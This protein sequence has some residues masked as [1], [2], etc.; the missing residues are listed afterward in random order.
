MLY[1]VV[2]QVIDQT[3]VSGNHYGNRRGSNAHL[4]N[5]P[6][7]GDAAMGI[8]KVCML[9]LGI[10]FYIYCVLVVPSWQCLF[11]SYS[12]RDCCGAAVVV[13]V[14]VEVVVVLVEVVV[15]ATL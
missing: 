15:G 9:D 5:L 12:R 13:V 1:T 4:I 10:Y 6:R 3:V 8:S 14:V 11:T 7:P 2:V